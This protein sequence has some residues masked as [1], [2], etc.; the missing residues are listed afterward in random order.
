LHGAYHNPFASSSLTGKQD[1]AGKGGIRKE[2]RARASLREHE[3]NGSHPP[4]LSPR[5]LLPPAILRDSQCDAFQ[6]LRLPLCCCAGVCRCRLL[7]I[8]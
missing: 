3:D 4:Q 1:E 2:K 6:A 8:D 5:R 7:F